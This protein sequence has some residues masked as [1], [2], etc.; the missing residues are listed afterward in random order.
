LIFLQNE[1]L[2][3]IRNNQRRSRA[4]RLDYIRELEQKAQ[5]YDE[6]I[7]RGN[8]S[9]EEIPSQEDFKKLQT[10]NA[11]MRGLLKTLDVHFNPLDA[12]PGSIL[13]LDPCISTSVRSETL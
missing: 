11:W 7:A 1:D 10:E 4:K 8:H 9:P 5:K 2:A 3:R 6:I 12:P 13:D